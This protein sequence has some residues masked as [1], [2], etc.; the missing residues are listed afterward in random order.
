MTSNRPRLPGETRSRARVWWRWL[1]KS[2]PGRILLVGLAIKLQANIVGFLFPSTWTTLDA[3]DALGSLIVLFIV[4]YLL[5][6]GAVLAKRRL[7]WRVRR[8]LILSYVFVG[9]VPGLLI[10]AFFLIAGFLLFFNVSSYI[11]QARV[12]TIVD[13]ARFSAQS[14][15]LEAEHGDPPEVLRRRLEQR[16]QI[17]EGRLPFTSYA[18]IPVAGLDCPNAPTDVA[19]AVRSM[20]FGPWR[21]L[22][23]PESLPRWIGCDGYSGLLAFEV[24]DGDTRLHR[25]VMRA[26]ALP[27]VR[28]PQW[29]VVVDVPLTSAIEQRLREETGIQLGEVTALPYDDPR[30][31][32]PQGQLVEPRPATS[33]DD[34]TTL[35][36]G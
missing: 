31:R 15:V 9:L 10:I 34:P 25:L 35:G 32:L 2:L 19:P 23:A 21:H 36:T 1:L 24:A 12:R 13:Q 18:V 26:V 20:Q 5:T 8:K 4:A 11:L 3:V 17:A 14:A 27:N 28:R 29:A 22:S 33:A 30:L 6:K 16:Q 7:L